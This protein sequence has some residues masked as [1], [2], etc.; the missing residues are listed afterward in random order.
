MTSPGARE[1]TSALRQS[2][3]VP[4]SHTI[5]SPWRQTGPAV[6]ARIT[7]DEA[8]R[9]KE[10]VTLISPCAG[11]V[12]VLPGKGQCCAEPL[13]PFSNLVWAAIEPARGG[14]TINQGSA[15]FLRK[16]KEPN[17]KSFLFTESELLLGGDARSEGTPLPSTGYLHAGCSECNL[18]G[19][20]K[21]SG[22][23]S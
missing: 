12:I 9:G 8:A 11:L 23:G 16:Q 4:P 22:P 19:S 15:S 6:T 7:D 1:K 17:D 14:F 2:R 18:Q 10:D 20:R 21:V 5:P 3:C 13:P